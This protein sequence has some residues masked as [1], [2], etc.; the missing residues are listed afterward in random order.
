MMKND[1]DIYGNFY[2]DNIYNKNYNDLLRIEKR[3]L[4]PDD[5][6]YIYDDEEEY[7]NYKAD[8]D[9]EFNRDLDLFED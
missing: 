5:I 2:F 8:L 6:D 4:E 7:L 1:Y 9:Y 3:R